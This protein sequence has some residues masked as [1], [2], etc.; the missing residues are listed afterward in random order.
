LYDSLVVFRLMIG[1]GIC[2]SKQTHSTQSMGY[3]GA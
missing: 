1:V 2:S 3:C